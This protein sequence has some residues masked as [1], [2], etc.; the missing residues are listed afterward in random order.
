[1]GD[2]RFHDRREQ[3][4]LHVHIEQTRDA[5]DG[6][7]RVQRA[8]NKVT[9]HRRANRDVRGFDVANLA[10]HHHV[11]ILSQNVTETFGERQIDLR[12]H[13]DLRNTGQSIFH[14]FFNRDD[15][16]LD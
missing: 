11:R 8:E 12:F 14:R 7:I 10:D 3:K 6:I 2:K 16:A 1:M 13:V 9:S 15:A 5:A 4:R